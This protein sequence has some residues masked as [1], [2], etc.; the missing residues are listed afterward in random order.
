MHS[1]SDTDSKPQKYKRKRGL[2]G[3]PIRSS[4]QPRKRLDAQLG[5]YRGQDKPPDKVAPRAKTLTDAKLKEMLRGKTREVQLAP[6]IRPRYGCW[7]KCTQCVS[8]IGGDQCRFRNYRVF[9]LN[10]E[11]AEISGPGKFEST[12]LEGTMTSLP[13][14]FNVELTE[15]H[16]M[17]TEQTV[18]PLLL[19]Y[20]TQ[21]LR[22]VVKHN[23]I[24][25]PVDTAKH[26]AVCD[27][28]ASTVFGG[29]WFCKKCGRDFCLLCERYFSDSIETMRESPWPLPDAAR[30]RLHHC[31]R[32]PDSELP[33]VNR[34]PRQRKYF[35]LRGDLQPTSR[36]TREELESNWLA[37]VNYVLEPGDDFTIEER[38]ASL[39]LEDEE[40]ELSS[41]VRQW[42]TSQPAASPSSDEA[43]S[44]DD[45]RALYDAS[46]EQ[47]S[48]PDASGVTPLPY[49]FIDVD[50]LHNATF[51]QLWARGE[52]IVVDNVG[53]RLKEDWSPETFIERFGHE[54][55]FIVDCISEMQELTTVGKFFQ[56]FKAGEPLPPANE[57]KA[58][59]PA[60]SNDA[61]KPSETQPLQTNTANDAAPVAEGSRPS[62]P[63][64]APSTAMNVDGP[65]VRETTPGQANGAVGGSAASMS[66]LQQSNGH[67]STTQTQ[68]NE[69]KL[70]QPAPDSHTPDQQSQTPQPEEDRATPLN[71][72]R[73]SST[74]SP[75]PSIH[76]SP[77]P[78]S[79]RKPDLSP[80]RD[81]KK[82]IWKLKVR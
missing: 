10:P 78:S 52:P 36:F 46:K 6:C 68:S 80:F 40:E 72:I 50:K 5:I 24:H 2:D 70:P 54:K 58:S 42:F 21:E 34:P 16:I 1:G 48:V 49:M 76:N 53:K 12:T 7:G 38:I 71:R 59:L 66:A 51:N 63:P 25:R 29:F 77:A 17:R 37:L 27:F 19:S 4:K 45:V 74:L 9:P 15:E 79:P 73:S 62:T 18:A 39:G 55:C 32:G 13:D 30:P 11:T 35:H 67:A 47:P 57:D 3:K 22:H 33:I 20:I 81:G 8:K 75:V 43:M 82:R 14:R 26:R 64:P 44:E 56:M 31:T 28:C 65:T 23:A 60:E 69:E 61:G 41:A